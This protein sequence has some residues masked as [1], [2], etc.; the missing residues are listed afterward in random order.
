MMDRFRA[1]IRRVTYYG[2]ALALVERNG[3]A[4]LQ[5]RAQRMCPLT[6][7]VF[8]CRGR[9]W[10]LSEHM[11]DQEV[12]RTCYAAVKM[13]EEHELNERFMVDGERFLNPHPEGER[14][15]NRGMEEIA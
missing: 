7:E 9:K 14:P 6:K 1:L 15:D 5:V 11:T 8:S 13:F 3:L 2:A 10:Y 12:F 4:F